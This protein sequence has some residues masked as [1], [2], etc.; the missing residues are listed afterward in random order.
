[1]EKSRLR[2]PL[3]SSANAHA[4]FSC[5]LSSFRSVYLTLCF[6]VLAFKG[7]PALLL[8]HDMPTQMGSGGIERVVS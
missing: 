8:A 7:L 4:N 3:T 1:M 2:E 6:V 5:H